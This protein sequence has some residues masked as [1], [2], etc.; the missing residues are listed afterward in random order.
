M[1]D[2]RAAIE[3]VLAATGKSIR[4]LNAAEQGL[5]EEAAALKTRAGE[6]EGQVEALRS[7]ARVLGTRLR[8]LDEARQ[9]L[10]ARSN[11]LQAVKQEIAKY[12]EEWTA[13]ALDDR[14][15]MA[16]LTKRLDEGETLATRVEQA[17]GPWMERIEKSLHES[18][19]AQKTALLAI[20]GNVER[21]TG[22]GEALLEKFGAAW[23]GALEGF[24]AEWRRTRRWTVPVL[25]LVLVLMLPT[26]PVMGALGQS[27]FGVFSPY[28]DT[29]GWKRNV[30]EQSG[31]QVKRCLKEAL[32]SSEPVTCTFEVRW[33]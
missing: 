20:H 26:L 25:A 8:Q 30:W 33:K 21:L 28:D 4:D 24:R 29:N 18:V 9:K 31:E 32:G 11:E 6:I 12:Y 27:E 19:K 3:T 10:D 16:A 7:G 14:Q 5:G 13:A 1:S 2:I 15:E 17:I 23:E 22:S